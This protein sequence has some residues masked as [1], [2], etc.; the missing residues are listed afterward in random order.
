MM[1][2]RAEALGQPGMGFPCRGHAFAPCTLLSNTLPPA[3]G[4]RHGHPLALTCSL[5]SL[6]REATTRAG[7]S[8]TAQM[9]AWLVALGLALP[10]R[11]HGLLPASG[12]AR[13]KAGQAPAPRTL[14]GVSKPFLNARFS[15][16]PASTAQEPNFTSI[17]PCICRHCLLH[18]LRRH[19]PWVDAGS[20]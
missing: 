19:S 12:P 1:G 17:F 11:L 16:S 4:F 7:Q 18:S 10:T 15:I 13:S 6:H 14:P 3:L 20:Q 2:K 8:W 9:K 5:C